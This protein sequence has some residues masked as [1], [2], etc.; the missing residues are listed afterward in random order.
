MEAAAPCMEAA[1]PFMEAAAPFMEA[2]VRRV[3]AAVPLACTSAVGPF[4]MAMRSR[5]P[6][7]LTEV[8][9]RFRACPEIAEEFFVVAYN[10]TAR[11]GPLLP[12]QPHMRGTLFSVK[13]LSRVCAY[14]CGWN[15]TDARILRVKRCCCAYLGLKC[16]LVRVSP[17]LKCVLM[18]VS[19]SETRA[20]ARILF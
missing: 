8:V 17:V 18:R 1:V 9:R 5:A 15:A 3:R 12:F 16:V 14:T 19:C 7:A 2:A 4:I 20:G 10:P 6:V 11:L 13:R